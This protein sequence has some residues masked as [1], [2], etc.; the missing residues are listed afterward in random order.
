MRWLAMTHSLDCRRIGAEDNRMGKTLELPD[1][2][3]TAV[4]ARAVRAG[5]PVQDVAAQL[6]RQALA[7]DPNPVIVEGEESMLA[8][9]EMTQKFVAGE[10]GVEL[11]GYEEGRTNDRRKEGERA[12][13]WR[14]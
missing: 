11:A 4:T 14:D 8:R 1:D 2:V 12:R 13:A 7:V 3:M 10:W 6:L 9:R 5:Q